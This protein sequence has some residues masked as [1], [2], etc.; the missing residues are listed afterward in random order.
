MSILLQRPRH[1]FQLITFFSHCK[2][3]LF[4]RRKKAAKQQQNSIVATGHVRFIHKSRL[5]GKVTL[6]TANKWGENDVWFHVD[7]CHARRMPMLG[8]N[9]NVEYI[10]SRARGLR[11]LSVTPR[12]K[13]KFSNTSTASHWRSG[14][15]QTSGSNHGVYA[16]FKKNSGGNH[17]DFASFKTRKWRTGGRQS[18]DKRS[19]EKQSPEWVTP[20]KRRQT[21]LT[22]NKPKPTKAKTAR[23][24]SATV[25]KNSPNIRV[26]KGPAPNGQ[27]GFRFKRSV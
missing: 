23:T 21:K 24:V 3:C 1:L 13:S 26:A 5:W 19:P 14:T 10:Y 20:D 6:S 15:S 22:K 12:T 18:P 2:M 25:P 27:H 9:V 11:A 7:T 17:G 8:D 16:S 4:W